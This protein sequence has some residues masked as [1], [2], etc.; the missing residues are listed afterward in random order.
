MTQPVPAKPTVA[1]LGIDLDVVAW[2]RSV[3]GPGAIEVAFAT[4]AG[5]DWVLLRVAGD[6]GQRVSVFTRHEWDCFLDGAKNGEFDPA[7][8]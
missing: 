7:P 5:Q 8:T 1:Q 2:R 6:L 3:G 4:A